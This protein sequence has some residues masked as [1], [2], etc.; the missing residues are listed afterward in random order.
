MCTVLIRNRKEFLMASTDAAVVM[1]GL[2]LEG[3]VLLYNQFVVDVH[4]QTF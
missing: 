3:W 2:G 4:M 1:I